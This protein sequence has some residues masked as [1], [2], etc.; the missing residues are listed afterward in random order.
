MASDD[1]AP[2]GPDQQ[3]RQL[4]ERAERDAAKATERI[5]GGA[6]FGQSLAL[7]TENVMALTRVGNDGLDA[8]LRNLRLAG[9][10]DLVHL[11]KQ[12]NRTEDKLERVLQEVEALRD[13]VA[14][15]HAARGDAGERSSAPAA[16]RAPARRAASSS[17]TSK[18]S[19]SSNGGR[20]RP[21]GARA[22]SSSSAS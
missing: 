16:R 7:L 17:R 2:T 15:L 22:G 12:L 19:A 10:R 5:V 18:R 20:K 13:E 4:Y 1:A 21:A 6:G 8:A 14:A 9:R 3:I 11:G